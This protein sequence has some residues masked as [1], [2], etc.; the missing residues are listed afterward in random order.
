MFSQLALWDPFHHKMPGRYIF[1]TVPAMHSNVHS[2]VDERDS[3]SRMM[4]LIKKY[5]SATYSS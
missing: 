1:F 4:L 2:I 3:S 5:A